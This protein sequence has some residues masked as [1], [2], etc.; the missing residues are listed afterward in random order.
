[1]RITLC[2]LFCVGCGA[3]TASTHE[4]DPSS[5]PMDTDDRC[6]S[7][8]NECIEGALVDDGCPEPSVPAV[9]FAI[10]SDVLDEDAERQLEWLG[11]DGRELRAGVV[12]RLVPELAPDEPPELGERR[13]LAVRGALVARGVPA[14]VL[15]LGDA[16]A[17]DLEGEDPAPSR[18]I[19]ET[20][21][22]PAP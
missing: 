2:V 16:H 12:L 7:L 6:H 17:V 5:V 8:P 3:S 1:M 10:G 9:V 13:A 11:A 15:T 22:C 20:T 18:V 19:V 14:D 21:G 4:E